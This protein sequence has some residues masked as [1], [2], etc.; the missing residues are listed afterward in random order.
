MT[1]LE[2]RRITLLSLPLD[3]TYERIYICHGEN[4]TSSDSNT[5]LFYIRRSLSHIEL[6]Y[7]VYITIKDRGRRD[8]YPD[9]YPYESPKSVLFKYLGENKKREVREG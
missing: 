6:D 4:R 3:W 8:Q 9:Q 2:R 1:D 5:Q 7:K